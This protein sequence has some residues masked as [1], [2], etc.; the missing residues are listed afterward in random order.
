MRLCKQKDE[1]R[2][3]VRTVVT[4]HHVKID[5]ALHLV[6]IL[7]IAGKIAGTEQ[8]IFLTIPKGENHRAL[9]LHSA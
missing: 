4:T 6:H 3:I 2:R 5:I 9:W 1:I 7:E 8:T